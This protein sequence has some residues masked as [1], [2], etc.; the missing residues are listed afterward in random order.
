MKHSTNIWQTVLKPLETNISVF[1]VAHTRKQS[2]R[3]FRD[4]G[5][6]TSRKLLMKLEDYWN[7]GLLGLGF[8]IVGDGLNSIEEQGW[9]T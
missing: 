4:V 1:R 5:L 8:E 7:R 3:R 2:E 9:V 6:T